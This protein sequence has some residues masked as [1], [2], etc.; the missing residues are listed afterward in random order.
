VKEIRQ[1]FNNAISNAILLKN[2]TLL[3][4]YNYLISNS[5]NLLQELT[6][7]QFAIV[8]GASRFGYTGDVNKIKTDLFNEYNGSI[9]STTSQTLRYC[10]NELEKINANN[11]NYSLKPPF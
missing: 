11:D 7:K 6:E 10:T 9:K 5:E 3:I 8:N 1:I 4:K 2:D